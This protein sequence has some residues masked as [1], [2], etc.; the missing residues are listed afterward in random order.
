MWFTTNTSWN[1][2]WKI[3]Y[4]NSLKFTKSQTFCSKNWEKLIFTT[5][6]KKNDYIWSTVHAFIKLIINVNGL[7]V[8]VVWICS[9]EKNK[10]TTWLSLSTQKSCK[11]Y[12]STYI[13]LHQAFIILWEYDTKLDIEC[14]IWYFLQCFNPDSFLLVFNI[15]KIVFSKQ[16][17]VTWFLLKEFLYLS[18]C[19]CNIIQEYLGLGILNRSIGAC[20]LLCCL[21]V[22]DIH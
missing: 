8:A 14:T 4:F 15:D 22:S 10:V 18:H 12:L 9:K 17:C 11:K 5:S 19:K 6:S 1:I 2:R 13:I 3:L 20:S 21:N 7:F 16:N